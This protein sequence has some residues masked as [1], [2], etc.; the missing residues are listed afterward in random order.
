M[1]LQEIQKGQDNFENKE[2][3]LKNLDFKTYY[4]STIIKTRWNWQNIQINEIQLRIQ[5]RALRFMVNW[6][7]TYT[8]ICSKWTKDIN[9]TIQTINFL[10][11][12]IG[13]NLCDLRF[14]Q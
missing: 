14:W 5:K 10:E 6:Y 1:G 4:K 9:V 13:P 7:Y 3:G 12:K 2:A 8:N 11:E